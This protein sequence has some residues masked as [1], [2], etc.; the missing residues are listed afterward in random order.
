MSADWNSG[1]KRRPLV[2]KLAPSV[3]VIAARKPRTAAS[4]SVT[5]LC[6][7]ESVVYAAAPEHAESIAVGV[8]HNLKAIASPDS[9]LPCVFPCEGAGRV[10]RFSFGDARGVG[11]SVE[12]SPMVRSASFTR[13]EQSRFNS[14]AHPL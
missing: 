13:L 8:G 10:L 2:E 1:F 5:P 6:R 4:V 7:P 9:V 11:Q 12:P 14:V 3:H